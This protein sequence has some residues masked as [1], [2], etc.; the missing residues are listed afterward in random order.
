MH[1]QSLSSTT[2]TTENFK[3]EIDKQTVT[4]NLSKDTK[5]RVHDQPI[6]SLLPEKIKQ[7]TENLILDKGGCYEEKVED[8]VPNVV[9]SDRS[10]YAGAGSW[11]E[12]TSSVEF[13]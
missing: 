8:Q 3:N 5:P 7:A 12:F 11:W 1:L 10:G 4:T 2:I 9:L 6:K 13:F